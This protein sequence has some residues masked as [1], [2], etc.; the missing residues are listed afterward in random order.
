MNHDFWSAPPWA[1]GNGHYQM[2]LSPVAQ[3]LWCGQRATPQQQK[4]KRDLLEQQTRIVLQTLEGST[5][6]QQLLAD[7]LEQRYKLAATQDLRLPE[8]MAAANPLIASAL[9]VPEDL[10]LLEKTGSNTDRQTY[11]LVAAC[12]CAP[13]YWHLPD[14]I[15][16]DLNEVHGQVPGLNRTLGKR[17]NEFFQKLPA[18]RVFMRRNWIVHSSHEPF[19]PHPERRKELHTAAEAVSLVVR[20]ETQTLRRLSP[21]VVVFTIAVNCYPLH[22]I[23]GYP[24][25]ALTLKQALLSKSADER[26]AASQQK[27]EHALIS[28]LDEMLFT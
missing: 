22:E 23:Q 11:R 14:K 15:G 3:S 12:V 18:D 21:T 28:L 8:G 13:S 5:A 17:M 16:L 6:A 26:Q 20:T 10:C 24:K 7:E 19:Q 25:A 4:V 1:N 2:N 9:T 27:Y